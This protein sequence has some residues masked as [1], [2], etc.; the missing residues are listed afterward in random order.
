M[1]WG[2]KGSRSNEISTGW[3]ARTEPTQLNL[4]MA[5][6]GSALEDSNCGRTE[7]SKSNSTA[8]GG[9]VETGHQGKKDMPKVE[10]STEIH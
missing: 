1:I 3:N 4:A 10:P 6:R 5:R 8:G 9:N 7:L 2:M